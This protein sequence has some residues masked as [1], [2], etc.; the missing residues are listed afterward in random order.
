MLWD[1]YCYPLASLGVHFAVAHSRFPPS[2]SRIVMSR[3][4][5][6]CLL[7]SFVEG[8]THSLCPPRTGFLVGAICVGVRGFPSATVV[9]SH[10]GGALGGALCPHSPLEL[11]WVPLASR[12]GGWSVDRNMR[13]FSRRLAHGTHFYTFLHLLA[14]CVDSPLPNAAYHSLM[15][16][17][18][19]LACRGFF[20]WAQERRGEG[21]NAFL[22][23]IWATPARTASLLA[24]C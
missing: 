12:A 17:V 9:A 10:S 4:L 20:F 5:P 11:R 2:S 7:P 22:C 3:V 1:P 19:I 21:S 14:S 23:A 8:A 15:C 16:R 6:V 13:S 24:P 18:S